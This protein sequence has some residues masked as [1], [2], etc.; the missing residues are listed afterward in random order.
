MA[1]KM[2]GIDIGSNDRV[3]TVATI[4]LYD[5]GLAESLCDDLPEA[6]QLRVERMLD[7]Y[8]IQKQISDFISEIYGRTDNNN[9]FSD[10][11]IYTI[12]EP[13]KAAKK[14]EKKVDA[15]KAKPKK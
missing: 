9:S 5:I 13:K 15:G 4:A 14:T 8:F 12:R 10:D 7:A 11:V 3:L 2:D 6:E 1:K